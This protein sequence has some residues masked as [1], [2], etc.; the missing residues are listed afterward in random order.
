MMKQKINIIYY[1]WTVDEFATSCDDDKTAQNLNIVYCLDYRFLDV[2][3]D[4]IGEE[5][6]K[7]LLEWGI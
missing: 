5:K 2:A 3:L 4:E 6:L 7:Q 1:D